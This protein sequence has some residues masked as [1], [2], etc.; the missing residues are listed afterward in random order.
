MHT[1]ADSGIGTHTHYTGISLG[2]IGGSL[3]KQIIGADLPKDVTPVHVTIPK[4][5]AADAARLIA[6]AMQRGGDM[7]GPMCSSSPVKTM[8]QVHYGESSSVQ[9]D[10]S[11][12]QMYPSLLDRLQAPWPSDLR[13]KQR[14][15]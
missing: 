11:G 3:E 9:D 12:S 4:A 8:I 13:R 15:C 1:R 7:D 6:T 5:Q 14:V 2:I 10:E